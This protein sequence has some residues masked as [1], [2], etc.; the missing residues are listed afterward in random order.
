MNEF[1]DNAANEASYVCHVLD[2]EHTAPARI[3]NKFPISTALR[4]HDRIDILT[5]DSR[6][7][8]LIRATFPD[9]LTANLSLGVT[10]CNDGSW[11]HTVDNRV[12]TAVTSLTPNTVSFI[13]GMRLRAVA[14]KIK[15]TYIGAELNRSGLFVAGHDFSEN[16]SNALTASSLK[17]LQDSPFMEVHST[18]DG[19]E[20]IYKPY[21]ENFLSWQPQSSVGSIPSVSNGNATHPPYTI[22]AAL[23]GGQISTPCVLVEQFLT[24]EWIPPTSTQDTVE[25]KVAKGDPSMASS[26]QNKDIVRRANETQESEG[27]LTKVGKFIS[28]GLST[29]FDAASGSGLMAFVKGLNSD[30]FG[31]FSAT[32]SPF[33]Y[34]D[35][36]FY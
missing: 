18:A 3:P 23:V 26:L 9:L 11:D 15:L 19:I 21:D 7:N 12:I 35:K 32:Q 16:Y 5:S 4:T 20:V 13:S 17:Q 36:G 1:V 27:I 8:V 25:M 14:Y 31:Q 29:A 30:A 33:F 34:R 28:K 10:Y 6:G 24:I 2:P 22:V